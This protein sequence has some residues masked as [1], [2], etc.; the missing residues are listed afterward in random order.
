MQLRGNPDHPFSQGELCPKVNRFLDRVYDP[1]RITT[2][3]RRVGAKGEGRFEPITWDEALAEIGER[4]Q[5]IVAEH[6]GEAIMPYLSA[7]NQSLLAMSFG[8]RFWHR[9]GASRVTG[10]LCGAAAGAGAASTHG[11]GKALDSVRAAPLEAH[12]PVGHQHAPHQPSPVAGHRGG[13]GRRGDRGG[14]RSHPHDDRR[15]GRLVRAAAPGY[16][17]G[18]D[19]GD[20]ARPRSRRPDRPRMAVGVRAW[21]RATRCARG[22]LDARARRRHVRHRRR[23]DR[24]V[25]ACLRHDPSRGD[26]HA[27][28]CRAP[29]ARR[30]VL[31]YRRLPAGAR[32]CMARPWRWLRPQR[33]RVERRAGRRC[34]ARSARPGHRATAPRA[35]DGATRRGAERHHACRR[36]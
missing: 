27:H 11:T 36:R 5:Q 9:I 17:R 1:G 6:G 21:L 12:H 19:A 8:E 32:G 30:D 15:I 22:R 33:G 18:A 16:R 2:P 25:G 13:A 34:C 3:L 14:D 10:A 20:D 7:G 24:G 35:R 23:R 4:L 29:R 26:P 31:P 28:R